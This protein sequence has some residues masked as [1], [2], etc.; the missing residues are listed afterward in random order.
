M[1]SCSSASLP[2]QIQVQTHDPSFHPRCQRICPGEL[3]KPVQR[4]S[5]LD[6]LPNRF[7]FYQKIGSLFECGHAEMPAECEEGETIIES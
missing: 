6:R 7:V 5:T 2:I 1:L 4:I 3:P